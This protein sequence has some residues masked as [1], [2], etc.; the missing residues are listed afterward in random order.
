MKKF[1][2]ISALSILFMACI[3][4]QRG[5]GNI[6]TE[7][8]NV[9]AFTK[10]SVATSI[11]VDILQSS[12]TLVTVEAD[13]NLIKYIE[14]EVVDGELQIRLKSVSISNYA[15]I[16]VHITAPVFESLKVSSSAEIISNAPVTATDIISLAASSSANI[17]VQ[18]NAPKV[19]ITASSSSEIKASGQAKIINVDANSSALVNAENLKAETATVLASSSGEVVLFASLSITAN[20]NSSGTISYTGGASNVIKNENSSGKIVKL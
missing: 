19:N 14:T 15:T 16:K 7:K 4:G 18:L 12:Q 8:R 11:V 3:N 5:N 13:E 17:A 9:A 6:I 10:V 2:L 1:I 20:A